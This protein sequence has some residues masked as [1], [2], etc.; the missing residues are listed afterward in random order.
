MS[1]AS[2]GRLTT[3]I[4]TGEISSPFGVFGRITTPVRFPS[5]SSID[6]TY[7]NPKMFS[8]TLG[9]LETSCLV[10]LSYVTTSID[11][12]SC[13]SITDVC[14]SVSVPTATSRLF[15]LSKRRNFPRRTSGSTI[16]RLP[17]LGAPIGTSSVTCS[18]VV[19]VLLS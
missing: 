1:S 18:V 16:V 15:S 17:A 11:P 12:S 7:S 3:W 4:L 14:P 19:I 8:A 10:A 13:V 9:C 5:A 6:S 2:S